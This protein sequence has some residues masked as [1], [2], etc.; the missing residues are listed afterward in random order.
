M[1]E[2]HH[3]PQQPEET[4]AQGGFLLSAFRRL[5]GRLKGM[6]REIS[7]NGDDADDA[8]QEAFARL[9][10]R[11]ERISS[12][13]EASA[14]ITTTVKHLSVDA[15]RRHTTHA[16]VEI[17]PQCDDY[18]DVDA[19][20]QAAIDERFR[21]VQALMSRALSPSQM[22]VMQM[23][24]YEG[25]SYEEIAQTLHLTEP[26]VR[27]QLSRARKAVREAYR[28]QHSIHPTKTENS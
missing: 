19:E 26:T 5:Q 18:H 3:P 23:R 14:L 16:E 6:A 25:R 9:W 4:P 2:M 12:E 27:M 7:G 1:P 10:V 22:Q 24:D 11:R 28:K 17:D 13:G 21:E 20:R 15:Y 8:L